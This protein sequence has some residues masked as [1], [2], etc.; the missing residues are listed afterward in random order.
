MSL[1]TSLIMRQMRVPIII[2]IMGYAISILGMVITPG[3]DDQGNPWHMSFFDAF[4]FVSYT[5]TTIGFGEIPY[6]LTNAQRTWALI[7]IYLTVIAWFYSL[8]KIISLVQ[9]PM[10]REALKENQ[11]SQQLERIPGTF[12][13]IC[14]F[15]ET[16]H[17]LA[18]ALTERNIHT[19]VIEENDRLIQTLPL[20][21]FPLVIPGF[22]GDARDPEKLIQ[23]GLQ[24]K[25]CA[26][27]I[28]VTASD[29]TNLKIAV[30]SKLLHPDIC[31]VCRSEL[32]E[33]E[34]N[35]FSFGTDFV[36]NPFETFANIFAMAMHSP[37]LH[38]LY[39]WLTGVPDTDLTNPIYVK[40]GHWVICGF[41]RFGRDLYSQLLKSN[42]QVTIID[43]SKEMRENFLNRPENKHNDFIIGTG[44]DAHTLT[45]AGITE[46]VGL[47]SGTDNDTNNLSIIMT[48]RE[49]NPDLF[50]VARH[51]KKANEKLF[52]A[53]K[54]NIIMQPSEI[55]A[56]KIR[57]LLVSPL[58]IAFLNK[59][60]NQNPA[61]ANVTISRIMGALGE[62]V[63]SIWTLHVNEKEARAL[64]QV[65]RLGRVIRVGNL[66]QNPRQ[67]E[68]LLEAVPLMLKRKQKLLLMPT[69]DIAIKSGD[70]ILFCGTPGA[71]R[72][73]QWSQNDLH[74]LNY[75]MTYE[76]TPDAFIWR[77][78]H[79]F[80]K[81]NERRNRPRQKRH[82][83]K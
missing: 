15:G 66:L 76:D 74:S 6:T 49:L 26:A 57:T 82:I 75:I 63:P 22:K 80:I 81:R 52:E 70:Q 12:I 79:Q 10:F 60:R 62:S 58:M 1:V 45:V 53:T 46:A 16:G 27:V 36:I 32:E 38:L 37:S 61:W 77:K 42:V 47:I 2:L 65:L 17:A 8:G 23:A 11:F 9:D 24:N 18:R 29:E 21:D 67:R 25:K 14:G 72:S 40:E 59:A 41:G 5:A 28:A 44:F 68:H 43:P 35:M 55:I 33:Y 19:V 48:A 31:V 69:N 13:L 30:T 50:I 71:L 20:E 39:D 7:T 78:F 83:M 64:C 4:Y 73:M 51:N 56:R 54:A 3:I 34:S